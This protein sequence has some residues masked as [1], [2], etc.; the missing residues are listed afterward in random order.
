MYKID[1]FDLKMDN[2]GE[3]KIRAGCNGING[4]VYLYI[5]NCTVA[6]K[7][8][9]KELF[10]FRKENPVDNISIRSI[11]R[12]DG[13][14]F[15]IGDKVSRRVLYGYPPAIEEYIGKITSFSLDYYEDK[16]V[17]LK[18]YCGVKNVKQKV[19]ID[20]NELKKWFI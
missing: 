18:A 10:D 16:I 15:S 9:N 1:S 5:D 14:I 8:V 17:S 3:L 19:C 2:E 11:K 12:K 13:K 20:V 7:N 4:P 6:V